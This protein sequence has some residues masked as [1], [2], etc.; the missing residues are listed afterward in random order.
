M[1][2]TY[3]TSREEFQKIVRQYKEYLHLYRFFNGGSTKGVTPFDLFYLN[4][5]Y[6][7]YHD[8]E[9]TFERGY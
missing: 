3:E 5:I 9:F 6:Y 8:K 4:Q 1:Q 2:G 7:A